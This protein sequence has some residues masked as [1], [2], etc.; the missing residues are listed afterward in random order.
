MLGIGIALIQFFSII[1]ADMN[2]YGNPNC[3]TID[4]YFSF[5]NDQKYIEAA[6]DEFVMKVP[7]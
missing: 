1:S 7:G 5:K 2:Q 6:L 4:S 3:A